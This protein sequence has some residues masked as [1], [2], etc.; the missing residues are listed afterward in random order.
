M[1]DIIDMGVDGQHS[2]EDAILPGE[3]AY[4]PYGRR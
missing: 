3:E 1:D 4:E 2:L